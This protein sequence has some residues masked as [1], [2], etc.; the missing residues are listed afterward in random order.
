M[1]QRDTP[2]DYVVAT[3]TTTSVRRFCELA[4]SA[5]GLDWEQYVVQNPK[6]MRPAEVDLLIGDASKAKAELG[7]GADDLGRAA[8][9]DDGRE[10]P[11][12]RRCVNAVTVAAICG[13]V[14][15]AKLLVGLLQVAEPSSITAIV[16][17]GDDCDLHGLCICP[18]LDTITYTTSGSVNPETGWGLAGE[19]WS[20]MDAL[21]RFGD[22]APPGSQAGADW[23]R[24]GDRDIATH[25]Y[26]TG[27]RAEGAPLSTIT[28]EVARAFGLEFRLLP[29]TDDRVRTRVV[30]DGE[31]LDFQSWFVGRGFR[32]TVS[33]VTVEGAATAD[34]GARVSS[35]RSKGR[36]G[37]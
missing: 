30:V 4:F 33:A 17:V 18:D 7:L 36:T 2:S 22:V 6:F 10:R 35:R 5:A 3:G 29:V 31:D 34:A 13:G 9:G 25:L 24:L 8:C 1:L 32:G 19:T 37:S 27:R 14:G 12:P 26:R 20:A 23:F 28:A 21:G 15:A 11:R 16:N